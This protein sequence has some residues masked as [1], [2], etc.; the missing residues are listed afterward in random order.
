MR[1][2][3]TADGHGHRHP[4][5]IFAG[6][7][8]GRPRRRPLA[9][10]LLR[11]DLRHG[12]HRRP[13]AADRIGALDH[14]VAADQR[15]LAAAVGGRLAAGV[16]A[17]PADPGVPAAQSRHD[18]GGV[19]GHL[20]VGIR[21]S[22]VGAADRRRF[23]GRIPGAPAAAPDT[24]VARAAP[25]RHVRARRAA[26]GARL[27]HG[28]KRPQRADRCEPVSPGRA[29]PGRAGDLFVHVLDCSDAA[30]PGTR[31]RHRQAAAPA[32]AGDRGRA[33]PDLDLRRLRG[34]ARM[35]VSS[36]TAFR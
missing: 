4:I 22:A 34:R 5:A 32:S 20:L 18:A 2:T 16:H 31:R 27:V 11:H 8:R 17:L 30:A 25:R 33:R 9:A 15:R 35:A 1:A 29:F 36:T 21:P 24:P 12:G 28:A 26:R 13:H 7:A 10:R 19:Q 6:Q 14:G 23:R 3:R